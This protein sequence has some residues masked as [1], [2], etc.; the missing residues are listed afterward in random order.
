M[1]VEV[2]QNYIVVECSRELGGNN[3]QETSERMRTKE[4]ESEKQR[5]RERLIKIE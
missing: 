1:A 3:S 5:E 2:A 4:K